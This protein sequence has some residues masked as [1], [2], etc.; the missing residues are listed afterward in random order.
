MGLC[1]K[2]IFFLYDLACSRRTWYGWGHLTQNAWDQIP[3]LSKES[4]YCADMNTTII[5]WKSLTKRPPLFSNNL[6]HIFF[7]K[8]SFYW[9][10]N[11]NNKKPELSNLFF[12]QFNPNK[13]SNKLSTKLKD[14]KGNFSPLRTKYQSLG[15][16]NGL[17]LH[18][19]QKPKAI[20]FK[21][22]D[23]TYF[24][25]HIQAFQLPFFLSLHASR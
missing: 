10:S 4:S 15:Y 19:H 2:E 22:L 16:L 25:M 18:K 20:S 11:Y 1:Q 21:W 7:T 6:F 24:L 17:I 12:Y 23:I 3:C 9:Q 13:N 5:L 8:I 14:K